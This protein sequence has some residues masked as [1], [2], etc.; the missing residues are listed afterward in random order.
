[1][2]FYDVLLA[3]KLNG[4]GG[5]PIDLRTLTV[6]ENGE[7]DAPSGVA[8]NKV[9]T[10]VPAPSN[11]IYKQTLTGLPSPIA[12]FTGADAPLDS[13]KAS[14]VGVQSGSGDPSPSNV[15]PITGWSSCEVTRTGKNLI[16]GSIEW[17]ININNAG[18]I[19]TSTSYKGWFCKVN[20][21]EKYTI[22]QD[23]TSAIVYAFFTEKPEVGSVSYEGQRVVVSGETTATFTAPIDGYICWRTD[24]LTG[25]YHYQLEAGD[26]ATTYEPY[27][28]TNVLISFGQDVYGGVLNVST[29]ELTITYI[30]IIIDKNTS[31]TFNSSING[32][33]YQNSGFV[34]SIS[35]ETIGN[36]ISNRLKAHINSGISSMSNEFTVDGISAIIF[37]VDGLTTLEAYKTWLETNNLQFVAPLATPQTIQ[38]TPTQV[39]TIQGNN[40]VFVD[41]GEVTECK[42]YSETP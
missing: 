3:K 25:D 19:V 39:R 31:I 10:N 35:P 36:Y 1:M 28:G 37:K 13:L 7:Q 32:C 15:R 34:P 22:S 38:L 30:C 14:I 26:Q 27:N 42:Y 5:S 12:T 16:D 11:A 29:G 4:G 18:T 2:N 40:N 41:C 9:I 8:Y 17:K 6:T 23:S 20:Q 33:V 21:G 24:I